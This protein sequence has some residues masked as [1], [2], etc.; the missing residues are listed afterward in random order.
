M[1]G[2]VGMIGQ[3]NTKEIL[4]KG[5]EKLEYRGYDSA[6]LAFVNDGV[7]VHKEVGRIAALRE[8]VPADADGTVG[9]GHTRWATHG[10][11]SVPN[12]HP[13]QS[14][15]A[16]FTLVHNGVIENDEQLKAELNVDLLSDTDTEVIVQ[17]IEK[18]FNETGDVAE[19]FRQTLRVLHGS[20]A[21]ALIDAEN[22]DV[23]YV[24][25]NKSPLLVGIGDGTFNVVAS[26]AMAMLQVT[27]QFIELH[28]GEM[29]ILTR[30]SVTIQ[31]LDGNVQ[32]REAYTA[33]IDASDIEKGTYAHYMLKE[34]DEQ[35]AVIRNIV[36]KYQ[37]EAGDITLDQSVRDLVLGRDR[38]YIIGC[39]TSY[40]AGLIGKQLI[41]QIAGIPTEVHISSEFGY[42]MPL[43]TEKP[44]FLFLSQSGETA[45]S[46]AVLVEAKK[47]GHPALTITN[48]PGSTLSREANATLLLHAG[49]EIAVASTKAYTAQIAVLAVLA[50]DLAQ[51]K[52]VAVNFDLMKELGKISSAMES[53]M[54][55]KDRFQEIATEYLSESR[56][57]FFIGRGQDAY[58]GME[59]A[60]KLKEISYI[61]AEGYAGGELKHGPIALI[62]DNTPV[63]AL[64]TQPHVHLNNRG[65]V[66]EVVARGA[67]ACV[68]AA[69]GLEL[70]TDAFVIPAVEPL[71][72]PLLSVLPLQLISYY[73][74][75]GRDCDVDKPR[76]LAKSVT[77]E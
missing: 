20:Y 31:D 46:R 66:K 24:A 38:V 11:P 44:L 29:I 56:N 12:A 10:V 9:I 2:I 35:P 58:V 1:C 28:D 55:Q 43:L 41:E 34:M 17:M 51:A 45:D 67:N 21:L 54:S 62:E 22:P 25:K 4:L 14:A 72:S 48:V 40:H 15:S 61:Q 30:D 16:R 36:Q 13:H 23:L 26:D 70:P 71:L 3:V 37:N 47:L 73:A 76:N 75:L 7:Q 60:L 57:A 27:D 19:A 32:E 77:V 18:N 69:E 5:L 50:F 39:G 6:G 65:N 59:G 68:I 49:P 64:V 8:V 52:G 33:E 63:I 53:V 74:A 42:N